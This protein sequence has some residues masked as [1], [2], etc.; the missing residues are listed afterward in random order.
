M[1][2][3]RVATALVFAPSLLAIVYWGGFALEATCV[4]LSLIM[5]WEYLR[6][7]FGREA[8]AA[9]VIAYVLTAALAAAVVS[10]VP[11]PS[12]AAVLPAITLALFLHSLARPDPIET[13]MQRTGFLMLGVMYCGGLFPFL[14][15]LRALETAG[16]GLSLMALFCTWSADTGAYFAGR[17]FGRRKLYPKIS[18]GKTI[19]G[20]IGGLLC[21][22][23]VA[24][25]IRSL[26]DVDLASG[27]TMALGFLAGCVGVAGDL[28]ESML[29]RSV[30]AKD[31]SALIPGHGG[32]LD[33]FDAVMFVAPSF[34][35]YLVVAAEFGVA[36][37]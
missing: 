37:P 18:P 6:L 20:G 30:G 32:V 16:L 28:C 22:V 34:F 3:K 2:A 11:A 4:G 1:L 17:F 13:S 12:A 35:V 25:L 36:G 23:G 19:E 5:L 29:K 15:R 33:R 27:H 31:S 9:K 8:T 26:F 7:T 21:A 14:A 10:W 24:F